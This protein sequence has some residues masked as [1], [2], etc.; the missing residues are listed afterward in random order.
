MIILVHQD[1]RAGRGF[2]LH[3]SANVVDVRVRDHDLLERELFLP[4]DFQDIFDLVAGIE[5]DLAL[6]EKIVNEMAV[7]MKMMAHH[8]VRRESAVAV[9]RGPKAIWVPAPEKVAAISVPL[10]CSSSTTTISTAQTN[11]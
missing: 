7:S 4:Q 10:P 11:T 8:V 5:D 2:Q 6:P 3:G 9:P 1:G